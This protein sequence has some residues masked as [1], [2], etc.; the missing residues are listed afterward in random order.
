[1]FKD[2]EVGHCYKTPSWVLA[3]LLPSQG[4]SFDN[5]SPNENYI[6]P[7]EVFLVLEGYYLGYRHV[8]AKTHAGWFGCTDNLE[9]EEILFEV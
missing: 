7:N 1:M 6:E 3:V 9:F 2:L 5:L 4:T 8:L